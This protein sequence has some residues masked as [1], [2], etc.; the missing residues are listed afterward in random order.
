MTKIFYH[1]ASITGLVNLFEEFTEEPICVS[2][3]DSA[4][5]FWRDICL[6]LDVPEEN[7]LI[8]NDNDID[9]RTITAH[10]EARLSFLN[11]NSFMK[12]VRYII[13]DGK[14]LRSIKACK[15]DLIGVVPGKLMHEYFEGDHDKAA[16]LVCK[17]FYSKE[18]VI[19][20]VKAKKINKDWNQEFLNI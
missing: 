11:K 16:A 9:A 14:L 5:L 3:H 17:D 4:N 10:N 7:I 18:N 19:T 6:V 1:K 8:E 2:S 15:A 12:C 20:V 13:L